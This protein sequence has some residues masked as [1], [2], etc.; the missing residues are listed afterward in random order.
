MTIRQ[1]SLAR[2]L[3]TKEV[4]AKINRSIRTVWNI[5]KKKG[6]KPQLVSGNHGRVALWESTQFDEVVEK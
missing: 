3:T 1:L 4:A 6:L 5:A 2:E